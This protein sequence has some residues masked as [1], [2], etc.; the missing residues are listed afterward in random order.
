MSLDPDEL[1]KV[2]VNAYKNKLITR[3]RLNKALD[4]SDLS[5]A[6]LEPQSTQTQTSLNTYVDDKN[7]NKC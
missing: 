1:I 6:Q 2:V 3:K 5:E 7:D 4:D